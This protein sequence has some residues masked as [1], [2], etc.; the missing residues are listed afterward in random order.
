MTPP[1][2]TSSSVQRS[3]V[4]LSKER[5]ADPNHVFLQYAFERL[6]YRLSVSAHVDEFVLKGAMLFTAWTGKEQRTTRDLDFLAYGAPDPE[7]LAERL[8]ELCRLPVDTDDG[9]CFEADSIA[10]S[11]IGEQRNYTGV[12]ASLNAILSTARIKLQIDVGFGDVVTPAAVRIA[13]P[14]LLDFPAPWIRAYTRE[15]VV[16]EKLHAMVVLGLANSRMKDFYD[17]LVIV[18]QFSI[19]HDTLAMAIKRTF[20]NRKTAIPDGVPYSLTDAFAADPGKQ[21]Q[22]SAFMKRSR[23]ID[24]PPGFPD[25][26]RQ[27]RNRLVGHLDA[28]RTLSGRD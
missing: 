24:T 5:H 13:F 26:V 16:A 17:A 23:L 28:A 27:L 9:L 6:L 12:H 1:R 19:E 2:D 4:R 10:V 7:I 25:V 15:S 18:E 21:A 3:L 8:G 11:V 20:D 14:V 22:W